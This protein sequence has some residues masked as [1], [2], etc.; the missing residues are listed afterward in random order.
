[1]DL[2]LLRIHLNK[3][4]N[5]SKI[6]ALA[7][8]QRDNLVKRENQLKRVVQDVRLLDRATVL[9]YDAGKEAQGLE[10]LEN[11][12]RLGRDEE[13]VE[14]LQRLVDVADGLGLDERVLL[15]RLGRRGGGGAGPAR[16]QLRKGGEEALDP[17]LGH[18]DELA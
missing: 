5:L 4:P 18:L 12:G 17:G 14:L 11:V 6:D 10:V 2:G 16:E 15:G 7:V 8:A 13:H 3:S 9:G 1:M